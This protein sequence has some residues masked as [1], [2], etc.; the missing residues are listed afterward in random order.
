MVVPL[1]SSIPIPPHSLPH[2]YL[3]EYSSERLDHRSPR[4][5]LVHADYFR[6][7]RGPPRL[8]EQLL[9]LRFTQKMPRALQAARS[10]GTPHRPAYLLPLGPPTI[11]DAAAEADALHGL[12]ASIMSGDDASPRG[13][14]VRHAMPLGHGSGTT[15][16]VP[17]ASALAH[18]TTRPRCA[19]IA[20]GTESSAQAQAQRR[21]RPQIYPPPLALAADVTGSGRS[22]PTCNGD[23]FDIP[24]SSVLATLDEAGAIDLLRA[25]PFLSRLSRAEASVLLSRGARR[26][27][28]RYH[29]LLRE[30]AG[31]GSMFFLLI[32][33]AVRL[34][35]TD[36]AGH[37]VVDEVRGFGETVGERALLS[38][39]G[40][41]ERGGG[42][43]GGL[44][45]GGSGDVARSL[46]SGSPL[47]PWAATEER[48]FSLEP[49]TMLSF[50]AADVRGLPIDYAA[51]A[52]SL[53]PSAAGRPTGASRVSPWHEPSLSPRGSP[54]PVTLRPA[55]GSALQPPRHSRGGGGGGAGTGTGTG[56]G[57]DGQ[58]HGRGE[59]TKTPPARRAHAPRQWSA[60][61][62]PHE[63]ASAHEIAI[64]EEEIS[65]NGHVILDA[66]ARSSLERAQRA[67]AEPPLAA[68]APAPGPAVL[69][70]RGDS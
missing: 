51:V 52:A 11:D 5:R 24:N 66:L 56:T 34:T 17:E 70:G 26:A 57:T 2:G 16:F 3:E 10:L 19:H 67:P 9:P 36:A 64:S 29:T 7:P 47:V 1:P 40:G 18:A 28:P 21:Q 14:T 49:C 30:A 25:V 32:D 59:R 44:G 20:G 53:G 46:A 41:G 43:G 13:S 35:A 39:A 15:A 54:R 33:G 8:E 45:G 4:V 23:S 58:Q 69:V 37:T 12:V 50:A 31:L 62:A 42:L 22:H 27:V 55:R 61:H 65:E 48:A 68:V 63:E 60:L 6:S 38:A